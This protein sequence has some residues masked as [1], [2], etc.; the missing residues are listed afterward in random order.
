MRKFLESNLDIRTEIAYPDVLESEF[1]EKF[2]GSEI[3]ERLIPNILDRIIE[4]IYTETFGQ[5]TGSNL[6]VARKLKKLMSKKY[7]HLIKIVGNKRYERYIDF[8]TKVAKWRNNGLKKG[9]VRSRLI[10]S[11]MSMYLTA[12]KRDIT[13]YQTELLPIVRE[14]IKT[15]I[16]EAVQEHKN[17]NTMKLD[18]VVRKLMKS[19]DIGRAKRE[20]KDLVKDLQTYCLII[21]FINQFKK[22]GIVMQESDVVPAL[23]V[24]RNEFKQ[25]CEKLKEIEDVR[26]KI[27]L[28]LQKYA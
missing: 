18:K 16:D 15:H 6:M 20:T 3:F 22:K 23:D 2:T 27:K 4:I 24:I 26:S 25:I 11:L 14:E 13:V 1:S 5:M 8:P 28:A 7:E 9:E 17:L 12:A 21:Y 10:E 19:M